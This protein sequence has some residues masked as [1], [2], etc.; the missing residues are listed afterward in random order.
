MVFPELT[1]AAAIL[2]AVSCPAV[3]P[4]RVEVVTAIETPI[5]GIVMTTDQ[6]RAL[7]ERSGATAR[8]EVYGFYIAG[9][10][11]VM[12][13]FIDRRPDASCGKS[14]S[15]RFAIKLFDRHI[16]VGRD[17][18]RDSC[19]FAAIVAHYKRHAEADERFFGD[20]VRA[21]TAALE[22]VKIPPLSSDGELID[23]DMAKIN[24]A[25]RLVV[26]PVLEG[27]DS[28]RKA[29]I[30]TVDSPGEIQR[31]EGACTNHT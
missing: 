30:A 17:M 8:H 14:V 22:G 15:I 29:A 13:P 5:V 2:M 4:L 27:M 21:V 10:G 7:R 19:R 9:I 3:T 31:L 11:Y 28:A 6:I 25:I 12:A 20:Y 26:E 16:E 24:Q 1:S 23:S 18:Q